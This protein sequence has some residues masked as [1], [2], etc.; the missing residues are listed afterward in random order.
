MRSRPGF[1][2]VESIIGLVIALMFIFAFYGLMVGTL[3]II[4]DDQNRTVALGIAREK[5]ELI[6]NLPYD[7]VGTVSGSPA[8]N[9]LQSEVVTMNNVNY[10]VAT[11]IQYVDDTFD[12]VAPTDTVNIDY[13]KVRIRVTWDQGDTNNPVVLVT[14]IVPTT[15]ESTATGGT[16]WIEVYDPSEDPIAPIKNADVTIEAPSVGI[17]TTGETDNDGRLIL[18]GMPPGTE[19][20]AITVTK[21]GYTTDQTYTRD[22]ETNPNP[23]PPH[24]NVVAGEITQEYFEITHKVNLLGI[25][26]RDYATNDHVVAPFRMHGE[27]TIGTDIS[28]LPIYLYDEII[29]PNAGGNAEIHDLNQDS[30]T[31]E[32][33][34]AELGY[35]LAG[36]SEPLPYVANSHSAEQITIYLDAAYS[37]YT[38]LISVTDSTG[39]VIPNATV[40]LTYLATL[41]ETKTTNEDGQVFFNPLLAA[42]F[43]ITITASG[44]T[45]YTGTYSVNGNEKQTFVLSTAS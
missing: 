19:A 8:G 21:S 24:L 17:S 44:Y 3:G 43:N 2:L 37:P 42:T 15:I 39:A 30:Y 45:T 25:Q 9:I 11:N 20:Y 41:D 10:T 1:N 16:I 34:E 13:K 28:G 7:S 6:K 32:F 35:V 36:S 40:Q 4:N 31:I 38:A 12:D 5:M 23:T 26:L 14:N 27:D 18:P 29:T 22:P 33:D